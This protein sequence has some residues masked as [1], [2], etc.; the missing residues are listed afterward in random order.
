MAV[1][2]FSRSTRISSVPSEVD[3][4]DLDDSP[5]TEWMLNHA[6]QRLSARHVQR[7]TLERGQTSS[8]IFI[9]TVE[10]LEFATIIRH[11]RI[12]IGAVLVQCFAL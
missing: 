12:R 5:L 4:N 2:I 7:P 11:C 1:M 3:N 10:G 6:R 8:R 9:F